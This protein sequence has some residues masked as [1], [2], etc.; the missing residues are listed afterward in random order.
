M[1]KS[2]YRKALV[3][4]GAGFIGSHLVHSLMERGVEVVV[5][6]NLSVGK[7]ENLPSAARLVEGDIRDNRL[8][9]DLIGSSGID[10][11]FHEA[12]LVTIRGSVDNFLADAE[13]NLM[14]TVNILQALSGSAVKKLVFASSMAVYADSKDPVPVS[15]AH[16]TRPT[17]PYG[18][19]K[20]ACERYVELI[21]R[22]LGIDSV[23][24]RYFNTYGPKQ[25]FTPYVGVVT[26]FINQLLRGDPITI[27]G[28]GEQCR[29]YIHVEDIVQANMLA[30]NSDTRWG[31]FN[32][33]TGRGTT[34]NRIA[35]KLIE[36]LAP[37]S[38]P[39]YGEARS[40]E[41]KNSIA[42]ISKATELL[43]FKPKYPTLEV[44]SVIDYWKNRSRGE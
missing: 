17:S 24:L 39:I 14:G 20:L 25:T 9:S 33:G 21:C 15:E 32:V 41:L 8:V 12:A 36:T 42:D 35:Q 10:I 16:K 34:V 2:M 40:E 29:D 18:V 31:L 4:G 7:A 1:E 23:V 11:V 27:Y 22:S 26:I 43:G 37:G 30:M 19:A 6:D 3:T 44:D 38:S 28:D 13:T 5:L